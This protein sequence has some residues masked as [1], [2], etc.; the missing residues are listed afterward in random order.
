MSDLGSVL[1]AKGMRLTPQR[2]RIMQALAELGHGTPDA[3]AARLSEDGGAAL[4]PSTIYRGLEALEDLGFVSHTH[5]DHRSP[6][7]HLS[8][9]ADHIHLV[10]LRCGAVTDVPLEDAEAFVGN[11]RSAA[12]FEADVTHM[13]IHGWCRRCSARRT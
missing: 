13:A 8:E 12:G 2:R 11:L 3:I 5:L 6:T 7:Y 9:H 10:C 4:P 1:R